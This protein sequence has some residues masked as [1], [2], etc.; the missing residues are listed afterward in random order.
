MS[1]S[2]LFLSGLAIAAAVGCGSLA[3]RNDSSIAT[4]SGTLT[5]TSVPANTRVA[6]VWHAP[7]RSWTVSHEA[8]V[9]NGAFSIDLTSA[10]A[11]ALFFSPT[12][13][14]SSDTP[15]SQSFDSPAPDAS[16]STAPPSAGSSSSSS[17]GAFG[18]ARIAPRDVVSGSVG[19]PLSVAIAGFVLYVDSNGNGHLDI[20]GDN[21]ES[22]D[23]IVGGSDELALVYMRDGT[24]LDFE[25]LRD[26]A[27]QLPTRG[28]DLMWTAKERW[29]PLSNVELTLRS[30]N[31][32]PSAVCE[33]GAISG[34]GSVSLPSSGD[35]SA[36]GSS[37]SGGS[38]GSAGSVGGYTWASGSTPAPSLQHGPYPSPGDPNLGCNKDGRGWSYSSCRTKSPTPNGLCGEYHTVPCDEYGAQLGSTDPVPP[39]WPCT[40]AVDGSADGG[41]ND[42]SAGPYDA[43][44]YDASSSSDGGI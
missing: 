5:G 8:P 6:L 41:I 39:G 44:S 12:D 14:S 4:V 26:K 15:P 37:G 9:V 42:A 32:F 7:D 10:P 21:G 2:F 11:D 28:Y 33:I 16:T 3:N 20:S 25:K 43:G 40:V 29:L 35:V 17:G 22:P 19:A 36:G 31:A 23:Q 1:R 24:S 13:S 27:G 30:N 38:G 18:G 34:G